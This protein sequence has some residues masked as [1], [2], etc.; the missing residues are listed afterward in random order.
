MMV[1]LID[2]KESSLTALTNAVL[3]ADPAVELQTF[4][5]GADVLAAMEETP[6]DV[7]FLDL[8]R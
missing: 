2:A 7:A 4:R 8:A 5:S 1:F 3:A 6:C